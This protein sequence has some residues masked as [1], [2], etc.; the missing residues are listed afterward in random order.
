MGCIIVPIVGKRARS[1][2]WT[3]VASRA[4]QSHTELTLC[5]DPRLFAALG[6]IVRHVAERA[7]FADAQQLADA[8]VYACRRA[9]G[10]LDGRDFSLR[11]VVED[12]AD[13]IEVTLEHSGEP[14]SVMSPDSF[15]A[16]IREGQPGKPGGAIPLKQVDRVLYE[17]RNGSSRLTLVKYFRTPPQKPAEKD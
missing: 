14:V 11:L 4:Q 8:T 12:F 3:N 7:G 13:R 17:T 10:L 2:W 16:G 1:G 6:S 5:D 9:F 15:A